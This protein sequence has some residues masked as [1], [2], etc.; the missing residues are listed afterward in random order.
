M[1]IYIEGLEMPKIGELLCINIY[2]NGKVCINLDLDCK[3]V[4]TAVPVPKHGRL[5]DADA[6]DKQIYNDIPLKV[7]GNIARMAE[8]R[9]IIYNA[10]TVIE[11]EGKE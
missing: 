11:A 4:A 1:G 3:Q 2:P 7:F 8:M 5:I 9:N 6:L 10:P